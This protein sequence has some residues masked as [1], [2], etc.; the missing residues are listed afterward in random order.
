VKYP[1]L[2]SA[3]RPVPQSEEF[4]VPKPPKNLTFSDDNS[5]SDKDHGQ[6]EGDNVDCNPTFEASCSP[7]ETHL[8]I[9]GDLKGIVRDLNLS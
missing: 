9:Q 6:E 2:P 8:L 7:S 3:M 4:I 1:D 5:D